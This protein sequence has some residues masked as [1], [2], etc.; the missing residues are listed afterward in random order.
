MGVEL[1]QDEDDPCGV[2]TVDIDW[3][4]SRHRPNCGAC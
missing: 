4:A 1:I 3:L 2:R